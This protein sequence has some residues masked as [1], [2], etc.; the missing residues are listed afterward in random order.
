[1]TRWASLSPLLAALSYGCGAAQQEPLFSADFDKPLDVISEKELCGGSKRQRLPTA[2]WVLESGYNGNFSE[3]S[4]GSGS[5]AIL[6][7]GSHCVLWRNQAFPDSFVLKFGVEPAN[8]SH[9]LN[10]VFFSA[11]AGVGAAKPGGSIFAIDLPPRQGNYSKYTKGAIATYSDSY[12][13]PD[14]HNGS[15]ICDRNSDGKCVANLRKDPGFHL[16]GH[17]IDLMSNRGPPGHVFE[18]VVRRSGKTGVIILSVD[19]ANEVTWTDPEPFT[20]TGYIGLRQMA[21]TGSSRYTHFDV[22]KY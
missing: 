19:G 18:V 11:A 12:F 20:G 10:I 17:G 7:K 4:S 5:L 14:G 21:N 22:F 2:Q 9:G 6:N 1:M 8:I 16:V 3:A 13:R 15:G